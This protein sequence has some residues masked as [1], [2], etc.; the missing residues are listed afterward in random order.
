MTDQIT[1]EE[2]YQQ[3]L[4]RLDAL[5]DAALDTPEGAELRR[6]A[7][8]VQLYEEEHLEDTDE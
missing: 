1:T 2:Q 7:A 6:L 4:D 8:L 5:Y 3:A